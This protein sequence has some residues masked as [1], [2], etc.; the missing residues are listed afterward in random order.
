MLSN[1]NDLSKKE[2]GTQRN[3]ALGVAAATTALVFADGM[4][5]TVKGWVGIN[6][7]VSSD[8]SAAGAGE[9]T[10]VV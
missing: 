2:L 10:Q 8:S 3:V 7:S 4:R 5:Q 6:E 9:E 1:V